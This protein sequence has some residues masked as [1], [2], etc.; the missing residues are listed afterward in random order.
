MSSVIRYIPEPAIRAETLKAG[1]MDLLFL[2]EPQSI[3]DINAHP[4]TEVLTV[5]SLTWMGLP[6]RTD[7]PP[8][9][10]KLVRKAM[11]A[12]TDREAINQAGLLG[13][14]AIAY[15]HP[16]PPSDPRFAPQ[17]KPPDYNPELARQLLAE[18]GYPDGIDV[19]LHTADVGTGLVGMALAFKE[20]DCRR[21]Y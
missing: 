5:P 13:M 18:A 11:Q 20:S 17:H 1:G 7:T 12:A 14:G 19:T 10:N 4:D 3:D 6:M 9:D 16:I 8:F 2:L 15:D 21:R